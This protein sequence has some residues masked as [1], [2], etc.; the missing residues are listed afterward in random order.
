MEDLTVKYLQGGLFLNEAATAQEWHELWQEKLKNANANGAWLVVFSIPNSTNGDFNHALVEEIE[1][2][3]QE[4][5]M[6][7]E[8]KIQQLRNRFRI[9]KYR[10][11]RR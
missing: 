9:K 6:T 11:T 5:Q 1:R 7:K 8:E 3:I 4:S 2:L 10:K